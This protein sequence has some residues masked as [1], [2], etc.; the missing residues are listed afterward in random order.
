[1]GASVGCMCVGV[2]VVVI[3]MVL[4]GVGDSMGEIVGDWGLMGLFWAVGLF[5][6]VDGDLDGLLPW[7]GVAGWLVG[8]GVLGVAV[9]DIDYGVS[10]GQQC[11]G[12]L[13]TGAVG[14]G[15]LL[16]VVN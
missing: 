3:L 11:D 15:N 8:F 7:G 5:S 16:E 9:G 14:A 6:K 1:M 4:C 13:T 12:V 10:L 2:S